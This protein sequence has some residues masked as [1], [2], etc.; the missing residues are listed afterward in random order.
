MPPPS[1]PSA[2]RWGTPRVLEDE[3]RLHEGWEFGPNGG[4]MF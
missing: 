2:L 4:N 1:A 3:I